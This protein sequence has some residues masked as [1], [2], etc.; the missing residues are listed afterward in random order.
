MV[1]VVAEKPVILF[2]LVSTI[3]D[4][5][6]RYAAAYLRMAAAYNLPVPTEEDILSELGQR[7]LHEIIRIHSPDLPVEKIGDFMNDCNS[8]CDSLLYNVRWIERLFPDVREALSGL[9]DRGYTLGLYTGT[10]EDAMM[11]QLNYHNILSY[12]DADLLRGKD[13]IRDQ[14]RD[15]QTL[16]SEQIASLRAARLGR[17]VIVVGDTMSDYQAAKANGANFVGFAPLAKDAAKFTDHGQVVFNSY[18]DIS[19]IIATLCVTGA[20]AR[21][22][23]LPGLNT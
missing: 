14:A 13:N 8:A 19:S 17:A 7:N 15:T 23:S 20:P 6:P 22:Q 18:K 3:T 21:R 11:A 1:D 12:F 5:G 10:R 2:D 16:K 9:K 4:A